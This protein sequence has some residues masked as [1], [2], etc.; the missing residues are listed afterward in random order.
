MF[1]NMA[2]EA[3]VVFAFFVLVHFGLIS[4][5]TVVMD[6]ASGGFF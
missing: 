6:A 3:K 4:K 1:H 5:M 2:T